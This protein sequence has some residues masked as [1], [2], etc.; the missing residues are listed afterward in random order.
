MSFFSFFKKSRCKV[1]SDAVWKDREAK[2]R[3]IRDESL[4][5]LLALASNVGRYE[6]DH[7]AM[8]PELGI[9]L[10]Y[11]VTCNVRA[12]F[13]YTFLYWSKVAR[14]GDQIDLDVN[15]TQ[16]GNNGNNLVGEPRP[17]FNWVTTDFWAQG[18]RVGLDYR[19]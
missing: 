19:F 11:D 7:F 9:T 5:G 17:E 1:E 13:G 4:G 16:F 14:P 8:I 2:L 6:R 15:I 3:G 10:G 18:L 12:T